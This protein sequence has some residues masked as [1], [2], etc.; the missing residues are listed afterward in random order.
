MV[1]WVNQKLVS[2]IDSRQFFFY[3]LV[4]IKNLIKNKSK[5]KNKNVSICIVLHLTVIYKMYKSMTS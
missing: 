5:H 4:F 3:S 1:Q 2:L